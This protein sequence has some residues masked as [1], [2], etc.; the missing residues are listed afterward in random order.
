MGPISPGQR[1]VL[2]P[3]RTSRWTPHYLVKLRKPALGLLRDYEYDE[4]IIADGALNELDDWL[5]DD[6]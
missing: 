3:A 1:F 2:P 6:D 5:E 4:L